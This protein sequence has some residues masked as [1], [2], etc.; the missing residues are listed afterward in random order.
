MSGRGLIYLT[1][2]VVIAEGCVPPSANGSPFMAKHPGQ[3]TSTWSSEK[4]AESDEAAEK[5]ARAVVDMVRG[6]ASLSAAA[7]GCDELQVE[8]VESSGSGWTAR[9]IDETFHCEQA[10]DGQVSCTRD[11]A[12][13][14]LDEKRHTDRIVDAINASREAKVEP[15][16]EPPDGAL[17]FE[18]GMTIN[19]AEAA[20]TGAQHRW[21]GSGRAYGCDGTPVAIGLP[22]RTRLNF[23]D[24]RLCRVIVFATPSSSRDSSYRQE[25]E[26]FEQT[27]TRKYGGA[28]KT[29]RTIPD[30]CRHELLKCLRNKEATWEE[31]WAWPN[32]QTV[33]LTLERGKERPAIVIVYHRDPSSE[34]LDEAL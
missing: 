30:W 19:E 27:L 34:A 8:I 15:L 23:C 9:C 22:A 14:A 7:M 1:I 21:S 31:R 4:E 33:L 13:K 10:N 6:K 3:G 28:S 25:F 11:A 5:A 24:G 26:R 20:C 2:A 32:G 12:E 16:K 18:F 17:G 29:T